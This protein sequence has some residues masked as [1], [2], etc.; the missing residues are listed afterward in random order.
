TLSAK[1]PRRSLSLQPNP[2]LHFLTRFILSLLYFLYFSTL[3]FARLAARL[4]VY[5]T[6]EVSKSS[7]V[8]KIDVYTQSA[9]AARN[10]V[11]PTILYIRVYRF[12]DSLSYRPQRTLPRRCTIS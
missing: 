12:N 1:P 8:R 9:V 10:V 11:P 5:C 2:N 6:Q 7:R 4:V 3:N